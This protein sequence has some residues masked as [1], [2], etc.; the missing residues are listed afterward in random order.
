MDISIDLLKKADV[1][2]LLNISPRGLEG[3]VKDS[4][5]PPPVRVG[6]FNYWSS[7]SI[8]QWRRRRFGAQENWA[9]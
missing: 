5:F 6:K 3:M 4:K 7:K 1:C 8:D 2:K 9:P